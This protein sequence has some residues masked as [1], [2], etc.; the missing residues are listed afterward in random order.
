MGP[1]AKTPLR[2]ALPPSLGAEDLKHRARSL[3]RFLE[4]RLDHPAELVIA[5]SYDEL[6]DGLRTGELS[7]AWAPP[8]VCAQAEIG[9]LKVL[10]R[11]VRAGC[12][13]YRA[14]LIAR[15]GSGIQLWEAQGL[16]AVWNRPDSLAGYLLPRAY[17]RD[18]GIDTD[19]A[20]AEERFAGSFSASL[21]ELFSK[22]A[23]LTSIY[24]ST[25]HGG[26]AVLGVEELAPEWANKVE[27]LAFTEETPNDGIALG[28]AVEESDAVRLM[29]FFLG[30]AGSASGRWMLREV[31]NVDAFAP[32]PKMGYRCLFRLAVSRS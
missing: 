32:S 19:K 4:E 9:G 13:S 15:G 18:Q 12:T 2:L 22:Q 28:R 30:L 7:A 24:A 31:F 29:D 25:P 27:V 3:Q 8:L 20:F 14:A 17:L 23:D 5:Q 21:A 16:R 11:G 10:V 6:V 26:E 1:S